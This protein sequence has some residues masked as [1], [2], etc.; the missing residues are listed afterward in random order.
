MT[1]KFEGD[2]SRRAKRKRMGQIHG[3]V[4]RADTASRFRRIDSGNAVLRRVAHA[5]GL[6]HY[7]K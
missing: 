3:H 5:Q 7:T 4:G 1:S 2:L 6:R